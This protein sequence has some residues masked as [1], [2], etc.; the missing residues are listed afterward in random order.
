VQVIEL[1]VSRDDARGNAE[2]DR[3]S[4]KRVHRCRGL[5]R[6]ARAAAVALLG[7]A[8]EEMRVE[9]AQ[10]VLDVLERG[11]VHVRRRR[12]D[13]QAGRER[14]QPGRHQPDLGEQVV[15]H[16]R[17]RGR[18]QQ[19]GRERREHADD[20]RREPDLGCGSGAGLRGGRRT[21]PRRG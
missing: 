6:V 2:R 18:G 8:P 7:P 19:P 12:E 11:Q 14:V 13:R 15:R 16:R 4:D 1:I 5:P 17:D 21:Q 3:A 9:E 10:T 20:A